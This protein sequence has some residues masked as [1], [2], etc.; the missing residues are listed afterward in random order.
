VKKTISFNRLFLDTCVLIYFLEGH[1]IYGPYAKSILERVESGR[2]T[3]DISVLT[4]TELLTGPYRLND[5]H[6]AL[7][8][9]ALLYYFPNLKIRDINLDIAAEAARIRGTYD[10][11]T[12][13]S[14]LL[15]TALYTGADAFITNDKRLMKFPELGVFNLEYENL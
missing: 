4:L 14:L 9:H 2:L 5:D 15:A 13:D 12:P 11:A 1:E 3:A 7:E 8:Y 6:L 10:L